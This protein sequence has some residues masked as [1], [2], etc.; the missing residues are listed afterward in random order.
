MPLMKAAYL[1]GGERAVNLEFDWKTVWKLVIAAVAS[2]ASFLLGEVDTLVHGFLIFMVADYLTGFASAWHNKK[3]SSEV[4]WF[5]L[6]KKGLMFMSV[7]VAH[8]F[9]MVLAT[10]PTGGLSWLTPY[11][12]FLS[13]THAART[14]MLWFWI[15]TEIISIGENLGECGV[16]WPR[17]IMERL[18]KLK[19][20][21]DAGEDVKPGGGPS[22]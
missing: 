9:D 6:L 8:W 15:V 7:I 14:V 21:L 2:M 17:W 16:R 1:F 12:S 13:G 18:T 19:D 4:G 3:L 10:I 5:G 22:A 20:K 11:L